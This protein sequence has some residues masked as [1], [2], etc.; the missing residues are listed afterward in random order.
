[1]FA[2]QSSRCPETPSPKFIYLYFSAMRLS[3]TPP[4][5]NCLDATL[6]SFAAMRDQ[7]CKKQNFDGKRKRKSEKGN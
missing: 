6:L 7:G 3:R 1:V 4:P 5:E 2:V